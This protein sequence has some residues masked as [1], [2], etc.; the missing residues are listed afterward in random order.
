MMT[1]TARG[2]ARKTKTKK[3]FELATHEIAGAEG[4][5]SGNREQTQT[6]NQKG[7]R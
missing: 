5:P 7:S 1:R 4:G 6:T 2:V 3:T